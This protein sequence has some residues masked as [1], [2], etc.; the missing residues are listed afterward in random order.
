MVIVAQ[1][2]EYAKPTEQYTLNGWWCELQLNHAVKILTY[3]I[4]ML[5]Y[6]SYLGRKI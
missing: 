6:V 1:L 4:Q 5:R 3:D 2:S